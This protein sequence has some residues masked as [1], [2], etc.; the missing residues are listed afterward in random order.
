[1]N[2]IDQNMN[3]KCY[4]CR[5]NIELASAACHCSH[6]I[7]QCDGGDWSQE[8]VFLCCA[9]CNQDMADALSVEDYMTELY[10]KIK[11]NKKE[12]SHS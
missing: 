12:E 1:M 7:P 5:S 9:T 8:N 11:N 3:I 2:E 6:D 10:I 4:C